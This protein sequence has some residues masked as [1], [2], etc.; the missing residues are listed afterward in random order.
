MTWVC[1][2]WSLERIATFAA[3]GPYDG[4]EFRVDADHDHGVST[5][6]SAAD[7]QAVVDLFADHGVDVPAVA[8]SEGL[9]IVD[10]DARAAEIEAAK[11]NAALAGDLGA[12]VLRVFAK[13]DQDELNDA[14]ADAAAR[15]FTELGDF[16]ADHGVTPALETVHDVV[17]GVDEA[18]AIADRVATENFGLLWNRPDITP[19]E[20][21]R[22]EDLVEH[23]HLH[24]PALNSED[25]GVPDMIRQFG[26]R[27]YEGYFSLEIMRG[28]DL[29]E[30]ELV[31]G[32]ERLR[33]FLADNT[34]G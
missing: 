8:T 26:E 22:I 9:A 21:D 6:S 32:G 17:E 12:D 20:L 11:A 4:V 1:P 3:T 31:E 27:D 23:V 5:A 19:E 18:L 7:R 13:G 34:A 14:A 16:A 29:P 15:A 30:S 25:D 28:E 10:D 33:G 24:E 2:G